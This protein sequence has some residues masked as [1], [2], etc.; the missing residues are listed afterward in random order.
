VSAHSQRFAFVNE[1]NNNDCALDIREAQA[2]IRRF[3]E[4]NSTCASS[5]DGRFY[6][7]ALDEKQ[8]RIL[9]AKLHCSDSTC[10]SCGV[11][12]N[13]ANFHQCL[14]AAT[15]DQISFL[16]SDNQSPCVGGR[17]IAASTD[18]FEVIYEEPLS[19]CNAFRSNLTLSNLGPADAV[20]RKQVSTS[21][22]YT[23]LQHFSDGSYQFNGWCSAADTCQNCQLSG[24]N[25]AAPGAC[26]K[27]TALGVV[28]ILS[29]D[30]LE[31][32]TLG[33]GKKSKS[34]AGAVAGA[35]IG[36]LFVV[37][38]VFFLYIRHQRRA[39]TNYETIQ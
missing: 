12:V 5:D 28:Q 15:N 17:Q 26:S 34:T 22:F 8:K 33:H 19:Q 21:S 14:P 31:S 32:C 7:L 25:F 24:F 18:M 29:S 3:N 38:L 10:S 2:K 36:G 6:Q 13:N 20:C 23:S 35:T 39:A 30:M 4:T 37:I 16:I 27:P 11:D 1:F 9:Y